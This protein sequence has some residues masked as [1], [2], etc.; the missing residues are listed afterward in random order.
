M[1]PIR[2]G[3]TADVDIVVAG[4]E[5]A[6]LVP[7]RAIEADREAGLYYVTRQGSLGTTERL[8]VLIG[9]R[10]ESQT[11]VVEGLEEGDVL[12]LPVVPEQGQE[13][14]GFGTGRGRSPFGGGSGQ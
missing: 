11:Q 5:G 9:L 10:D 13:Q 12:V 1:L 14:Q 2:L 8:A 3:M 7:N 4:A 6:L